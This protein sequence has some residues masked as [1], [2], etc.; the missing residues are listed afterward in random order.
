M[1]RTNNPNEAIT[2]LALPEGRIPVLLRC[3]PEKREGLV[4][5]SPYN[6]A[7]SVRAVPRE[8]LQLFVDPKRRAVFEKEYGSVPELARAEL[9]AALG[10]AGAIASGKAKDEGWRRALRDTVYRWAE[11]Y[12][13]ADPT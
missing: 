12:E 3:S 10:M 11:A 5:F 6:E 9:L 4:C 8:T 2:H 13:N 1:P 7:L